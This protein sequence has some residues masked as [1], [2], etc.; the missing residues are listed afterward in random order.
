[1]TQTE[2]H[3]KYKNPKGAQIIMSPK[4]GTPIRRRRIMFRYENRDAKNVLLVGSFNGWNEKKHPMQNKGDGRWEK[5]VLLVPGTYEYKFIVDGVWKRDPAN[6][7]YRLN[8]F[9]TQNSVVEVKPN[10]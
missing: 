4:K 9:G 10:K 6:N 5:I 8:S 7:E 2:S 3:G 1:M